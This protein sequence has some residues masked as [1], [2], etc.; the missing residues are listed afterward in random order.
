MS[1]ANWSEPSHHSLDGLRRGNVV[2]PTSVRSESITSDPV[3]AK[4]I[5][6]AISTSPLKS[7]RLRLMA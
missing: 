3:T 1:L 7:N 6:A 2:A 4:S 5:T